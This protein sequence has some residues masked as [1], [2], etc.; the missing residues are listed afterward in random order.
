M[1]EDHGLAA[2]VPTLAHLLGVV[3][4][5]PVVLLLLLLHLL[6]LHLHPQTEWNVLQAAMVTGLPRGARGLAV[7]TDSGR[8]L[9]CGGPVL[10]E[11]PAVLVD[12]SHVHTVQAKCLAAAAAVLVVQQEVAAAP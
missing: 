11:D 10:Q 7:R 8:R 3:N 5:Q 6:L 1:Q 12:G 2:G 9:H 4:V